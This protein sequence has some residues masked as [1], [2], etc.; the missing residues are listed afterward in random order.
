MRRIKSLEE[1][2]W[3]KVNKG[4]HWLWTAGHN[5]LGYGLIQVGTYKN[6]KQKLAHRISW[7]FAYGAIP[8]GLFVLHKCDIPACV[9]PS[10]LFLGTQTDNLNDAIRKRRMSVG[11]L[12][13]MA[14]L[15]WEDVEIIR[16]SNEISNSE[17]ARAFRVSQRSIR[18]VMNGTTWKLNNE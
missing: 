18:N 3:P 10:H 1:R 12:N 5:G 2:F 4:E 14:K 15:T 13:G 6:P 17:L 9:K 16:D 8:V 11:E 7:E